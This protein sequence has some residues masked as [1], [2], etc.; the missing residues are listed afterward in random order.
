MRARFTLNFWRSVKLGPK[1]QKHRYACKMQL[2]MMCWQTLNSYFYSF[3]LN[4]IKRWNCNKIAIFRFASGWSHFEHKYRKWELHAALKTVIVP[5][6]VPFERSAM[7]NLTLSSC[8][9]SYS[10]AMHSYWIF[11]QVTK[12]NFSI[13][14]V[15]MW[16]YRIR[17]EGN[18]V[19]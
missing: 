19:Q 12:N 10:V 8:K 1:Y 3:T 11:L 5:Y 4:C 2:C 16:M 14:K 18:K 13:E 6:I 9:A 15:N 7:V 17:G